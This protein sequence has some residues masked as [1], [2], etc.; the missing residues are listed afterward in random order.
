MISFPLTAFLYLLLSTTTARFA[1]EPGADCPHPVFP[2]R[3]NQPNAILEMPESLKEISGLSPCANPAHLVA[4]NDEEG[5]IYLINKMDGS[6]VRQI[7]FWGDGDYEGLEV[8]GNDA[9][10][11]KSNGSLYHVQDFLSDSSRT[12]KIKSFLN[13]ENDVEGLAFDRQRGCLLVGC[14]GKTA[15]EEK[16]E[17]LVL[18]KAIYEFDLGEMAMKNK[19]AF[20]LT[21]PDIRDYIAHLEAHG[22][23][24]KLL[25]VF[26]EDAQ[27]LKFSP[28][29]IAVHPRTH[30]IYVSSSK[31]KLLLVLDKDGK[32][33]H[34]K[35]LKKK[36]H[37][38]PEGICFDPDGTL[39]IANEGK[40]DKAV[41]Y[42]FLYLN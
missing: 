29:A 31:G 36:I 14:K 37:A 40:K 28:S 11:I 41:I 9:Y 15:D 27:Q 25:D 7:E 17:E 5:I 6:V 2:Y 26:S 39:Y 24:E 16:E 8:V 19:P 10:V 18:K 34:L 22:E 20:L 42:K 30:N 35:K 13:K 38:Q 33:L 4:V 12:H 3:L 32:I 1:T 21:L 23:K